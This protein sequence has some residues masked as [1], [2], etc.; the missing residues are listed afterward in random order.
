IDYHC[1]SRTL[2]VRMGGDQAVCD[3]IAGDINQFL[4]D[5][6]LNRMPPEQSNQNWADLGAFRFGGP[7]RDTIIKVPLTLDRMVHLAQWCD[8]HADQVCLHCSVA[9]AMGWLACQSDFL[10]DVDSFLAKSEMQGLVVRGQLPSSGSCVAGIHRFGPIQS[11]IKDAMD[12]PGRFPS[13]AG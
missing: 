7:K 1:E 6:T 4:D 9:G 12:P 3:S 10:V 8:D 2:W 13:F 5:P 11:A